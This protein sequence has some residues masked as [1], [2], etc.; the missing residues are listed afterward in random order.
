VEAADESGLLL[1]LEF[2]GFEALAADTLGHAFTALRFDDYG[3]WGELGGP[4]LPVL[5]KLIALPDRAD[6]RWQ[7][8]DADWIE[9]PGYMPAPLQAEMEESPSGPVLHTFQY[10]DFAYQ[11]NR[12]LPGDPVALE[13]PIV[14]RGFRFGRIELRPIQYNPALGILRVC[15]SMTISLRFGGEGA[16]PVVNTDRQKSLVYSRLLKSIVLNPD[17]ISTGGV[18]GGY[19]FITPPNFLDT[20]KTN[21]VEWKQQKGFPCTVLSTTQTGVS[22]TAIKAAIQNIYNTWPVPPDYVVFVG[23]HD[24]GMPTFYYTNTSY[25]SEQCGTDLPYTLLEGTDYFPDMLAGRL[26]VDSEYE[27][28]TLSSKIR[29]YEKNPVMDDPNWFRRGLV[30]YDYG[31]WGSYSCKTTKDRCR[32]LMLEH[33]YLQVDAQT[34]PGGGTWTQINNF[35]NAGVTFVNYRG[36]GEYSGW[37]PPNYNSYNISQLVNGF[38]LPVITSIVCGGGCFTV[39]TDPCFGEAWIRYGTPSTPK[40]AVSF[41]GPSSLHTHTRWNNCVDAGIYQ[42][43][44]VDSLGDLGSALLRGKM[45]LY[46]GMPNNQGGGGTLNSVECYFNIY[47]I[48]GDPGLEIWTYTPATLAVT[49][50]TSLALGINSFPVTVTTG[51]SGVENALV[52]VSG[53]AGSFQR[54]AWT[55]AAGAALLNLS[56][57]VAGIYNVTVSGHNLLTYNGTL[58]YAQSSVSLAIDSLHLDDDLIAPSSGDNDGQFNPGETIQLR[59]RLQN[60][61]SSQTAT[62]ITAT[63]SSSDPYLTI[64]QSISGGPD[65]PPG[66]FSLL[67]N[68]FVMHLSTEAPHS[69]VVQV[70]MITGSAQ[71][72]WN[73]LVSLPVVAPLA[74]CL[75]YHIVN[76]SG[77]LDPGQTANFTLNLQNSGGDPLTNAVGLLTSLDPHVVVNDANGSW[78]T[79][80]P[81]Q[82]GYND[83]NPFNLTATSNSAPG[84]MVN[85]RLV[86]TSGNYCDTLI[87]PFQ[88]GQ[89][90]PTDP[91]GPDEYGYRCFDSRD[92][93]YSQAPVYNWIE[94]STQSGQ[95]TLNLPDTYDEGDCVVYQTLPFTFRYYG[96]NYTQITICS[97]GW[98]SMGSTTMSNFR[99]W[100]IPGALGPSAMIAPFWDD[101]RNNSPASINYWYDATN[102]RVVVEWKDVRLAI[103]QALNRFE[104]ILYDPAYYP[105]ASGDGEIVFQ[106]HTFNNTDYNENYCTVGIENQLQSDGVKVTYANL[107]SLGSAPIVAGTALKFSTDFIYAPGIPQMNVTLTPQNPPIQIPANGGS[108]GFNVQVSNLEQNPLTTT[109][110]FKMRLPSGMYFGP[111]LGPI[112]LS[113]PANFNG[114]RNRVQAVP[115]NF[116]AGDYLYCAYLGEYPDNIWDESNFPFT[117]LTTSQPGPVQM[118]LSN[119]GDPFEDWSQTAQAMTPAVYRLNQAT[120][121]PFNPKTAISYQLPDFSHVNLSVY[122]IGGRLVTMLTNGWQEPGT[123]RVT[124]DG[125]NLP[126]GLYFVRLQAGDFLAVQKLALVK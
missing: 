43:I 63:V 26:S 57:A 126:S 68:D 22:T 39:S 78:S 35:I 83:A 76:A 89:I 10:D 5:R 15:R 32:D 86:V 104:A 79:L 74:E 41:I 73:N 28:R 119:S 4:E 90:T 24:Q 114:N 91:A 103:N 30:V 66:A 16:N 55:D 56:G 71:G 65:A 111:V 53:S 94:A 51:G 107:W 121:N 40:G 118:T 61:G 123:H 84:W 9:L 23:D 108:F 44:F 47:N 64:T 20:L 109:I 8:I 112:T 6:W 95:V 100:N 12:W 77:I 36:F 19:L 82:A 27:L 102:H 98:L 11:Q 1:T 62:N 125:Q 50:S 46:F 2:P 113:L 122:D 3:S 18:L 59:G 70:P 17:M 33:G 116:P 14:A 45:E 37:T 87:V 75:T 48:L 117:K 13:T 21:L 93:A 80:I 88:V 124:F 69:H 52:C 110:W 85:L 105:T 97:N 34:N 38:K 115:S 60:T 101:L 49:H 106:Y 29:N 54:T 92:A 7:V 31:T 96:Q 67:T 99:N 72:S 81:G 25:Q 58:T 120:P 42:G